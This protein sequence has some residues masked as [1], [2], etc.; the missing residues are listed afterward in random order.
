MNAVRK[1]RERTTYTY[2]I[3]CVWHQ[4][5]SKRSLKYIYQKDQFETKYLK[6]Y[7][8]G[9][10]DSWQRT[11]SPPLLRQHPTNRTHDFNGGLADVSSYPVETILAGYI[12]MMPS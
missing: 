3:T 5:L 9:H 7:S 8:K 1:A 2:I 11:Y 10:G 4:S 12:A 6:C